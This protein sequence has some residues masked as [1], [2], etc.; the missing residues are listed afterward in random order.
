MFAARAEEMSSE[1]DQRHARARRCRCII[2]QTVGESLGHR[3]GAALQRGLRRLA[4][5]LLNRL[6]VV[7]AHDCLALQAL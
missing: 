7:A 6:K 1:E 4:K 2:Q 5:L 3:L